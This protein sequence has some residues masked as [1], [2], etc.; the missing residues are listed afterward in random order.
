M[1][2]D[3]NEFGSSMFRGWLPNASDFSTSL[4]WREFFRNQQGG[5][6]NGRYRTVENRMMCM[7][8]Q[9][10]GASDSQKPGVGESKG[11]WSPKL[12]KCGLYVH[13]CTTYIYI[14]KHAIY[15][16]N[17]W[18]NNN[19]NDDNNNSN[20]DNDNN[21]NN[22]NDNHNENDNDNDN[23]DNNHNNDNDD[24]DSNDNDNDND[25]RNDNDNDNDDKNNNENKKQYIDMIYICIYIYAC[26]VY[27]WICCR[28][29][30]YINNTVH[31]YNYNMFFV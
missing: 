11:W 16:S 26:T 4:V 9:E 27:V 8:T 7:A 5:K 14:Y 22:N 24:N 30:G 15:N 21:N 3:F 10:S 20:N 25:N 29:I 18:N 28:I 17:N 19:N 13:I 2:Q 31:L 12:I 6:N 23:D 1:E